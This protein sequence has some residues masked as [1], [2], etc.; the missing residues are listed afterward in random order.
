[1]SLISNYRLHK[2]TLCAGATSLQDSETPMSPS[3]SEAMETGVRPMPALAAQE[4]AGVEEE[5]QP[6]AAAVA[7]QEA[8]AHAGELPGQIA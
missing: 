4:M 5:G 2:L 3:V 8:E 1:M 7:E 6:R